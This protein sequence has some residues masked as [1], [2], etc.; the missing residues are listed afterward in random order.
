[1]VQKTLVF[2]EILKS[3]SP[4]YLLIT[5]DTFKI[6]LE[7]IRSYRTRQ[8]NKIPFI[9]TKH[10][11]LTNTFWN[12]LDPKIQISESIDI[13]KKSVLITNSIFNW[14]NHGGLKLLPRLGKAFSHLRKHKFK[15]SFQ[16][17]P[18]PFCICWIGK[19]MVCHFLLHC[20]NC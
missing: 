5:S 10:D 14:I 20:S 3:K 15:H 11:Y 16:Y 2:L 7:R 18:N 8:S 17:S 12:K 19:I 6:F 13:F 4:N 9:S 1:M